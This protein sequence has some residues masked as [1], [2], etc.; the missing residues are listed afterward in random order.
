MFTAINTIINSVAD[1]KTSFINQFFVEQA[2]E[3]AIAYVEAQR[4]FGKSMTASTEQFVNTVKES[5]KTNG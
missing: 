3:P 2:K 4:E 1:A 5:V